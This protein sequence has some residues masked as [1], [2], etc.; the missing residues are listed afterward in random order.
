MYCCTVSC[1]VLWVS[2]M[3]GNSHRRLQCNRNAFIIIS[4]LNI[5]KVQQINSA[6]P[7][8]NTNPSTRTHFLQGVGQHSWHCTV[9]AKCDQMLL[10]FGSICSTQKPT[11]PLIRTYHIWVSP[12][13]WPS[14][15]TE[16]LRVV[17]IV[18][19]DVCHTIP[20]ICHIAIVTPHVACFTNGFIVVLQTRR[21]RC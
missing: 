19:Y 21:G 2:H 3:Y 20:R 16:V 11:D 18:M 9:Q 7:C 15:Y 12:S 14:E 10:I 1:I 13:T 17:A 6:V 4:L 8:T 5:V